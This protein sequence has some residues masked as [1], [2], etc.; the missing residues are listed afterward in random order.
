MVLFQFKCNIL[1]G[2]E[3]LLNRKVLIFFFL[4]WGQLVKSLFYFLS[5]L[6]KQI[7]SMKLTHSCGI[8][9][10]F[11]FLFLAV[12]VSASHG[13][14]AARI[15]PDWR[16]GSWQSWASGESVH[17]IK[18]VKPFLILDPLPSL[19][20]RL[21][22]SFRGFDLFWLSSALRIP[23]RFPGGVWILAVHGLS[24]WATFAIP[25]GASQKCAGILKQHIKTIYMYM[26]VFY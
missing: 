9:W 25:R 11:G 1:R 26:H 16:S 5:M 3:P 19:G 22:W 24:L 13:L 10:G 4:C 12:R 23:H 21:D 20:L 15:Y 6:V 8:G 18:M 17:D 2:M 14:K 7:Y